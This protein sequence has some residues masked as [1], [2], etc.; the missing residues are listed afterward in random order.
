MVWIRQTPARK[1][2]VQDINLVLGLFSAEMRYPGFP[3]SAGNPA[4]ISTQGRL[5]A[6]S[7][8]IHFGKSS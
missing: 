7:R 6:M 1:A 4:A 5:A 2:G 3:A 8:L